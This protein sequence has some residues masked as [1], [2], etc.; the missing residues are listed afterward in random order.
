MYSS[1]KLSSYDHIYGAH[2]VLV[3]WNE[4]QATWLESGPGVPWSVA[5]AD[6][7]GTDIAAQADDQAAVGWD[8]GWVEFDVT[9][10]VQ[11]VSVGG[12]ANYGWRLYPLGGNGNN[13]RVN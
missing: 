10:S 2:R 4:S 3:P 13:K 9:A 12:S 6:G 1:S 5:G 8:P 7:L 11:Q